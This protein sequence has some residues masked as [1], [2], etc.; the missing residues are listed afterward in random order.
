MKRRVCETCFFFEAA[1]LNNSG[2]CRHPN[3]QFSS[4]VRLIVRGNEIACRNGWDDDLWVSREID[5]A[6]ANTDLVAD[7]AGSDQITSIIPARYE[8]AVAPAPSQERASED[9]VVGHAPYS[10]FAGTEKEA[11]ELVTNPKAA[12]ARAREQ[13]KSRQRREGRLSDAAGNNPPLIV[14]ATNDF[15]ASDWNLPDDDQANWP[16]TPENAPFPVRGASSAPRPQINIVPPVTREEMQR[17][18]PTITSFAED[19]ERFGSVPDAVVVQ[20]PSEPSRFIDAEPYDDDFALPLDNAELWEPEAADARELSRAPRKAPR[21]ESFVNRILRERRERRLASE[22]ADYEGYPVEISANGHRDSLPDHH[23]SIESAERPPS[24][25]V[26]PDDMDAYAYSYDADRPVS[27]DSGFMDTFEYNGERVS[28]HAG[29]VV[30]ATNDRPDAL[31]RTGD[32]ARV[33]TAWLEDDLFEEAPV[34]NVRGRL[35]TPAVA[36]R[37][38]AAPS[39]L[40]TTPEDKWQHTETDFDSPRPVRHPRGPQP[41]AFD[42]LRDADT[43]FRPYVRDAEPPFGDSAESELPRWNSMPA[44]ARPSVPPSGRG[45]AAFDADIPKI[46]RTCRDYRPS[47]LPDRGWCNNLW[48]FPHRRMVDADQLSCG[49]SALG[50]WWAA[51]DNFWQGPSDVSR[52]AQETPLLNRLLAARLDHQEGFRRSGGESG[53]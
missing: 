7:S 22:Y 36:A 25:A 3:R 15:P 26:P 48:A 52:H 19:D 34:R 33:S 8:P 24:T 51:N 41:Q 28:A 10:G 37:A 39:R 40:D 44:Q 9:I 27:R 42:D 49:S 29:Q 14:D 46:C 17:P 53:R 2:W 12:I 16:D 23:R 35:G 5:P 30:E 47:D 31:R 20:S 45:R 32:F 1:G 43:E 18:Y 6:D 13:F 21:R 38:N 11:R 50:S 4:G